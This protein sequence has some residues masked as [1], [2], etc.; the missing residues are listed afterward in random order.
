MLQPE[1]ELAPPNAAPNQVFTPYID[2]AGLTLRRHT[3]DLRVLEAGIFPTIAL[4]PSVLVSRYEF[5]CCVNPETEDIEQFKFNVP[6]LPLFDSGQ[7]AFLGGLHRH[8]SIARI[9]SQR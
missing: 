7:E 6:N 4:G 5:G 9:C 3:L 2:D 8:R 1:G